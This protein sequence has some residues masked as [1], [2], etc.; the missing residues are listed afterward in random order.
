MASPGWRACQIL[1]EE[2]MRE[3]EGKVAVVTGAASGIGRALAER[4]ADAKM[5]VVLA[6][7]EEAPLREAQEALLE[8]GV[9][10]IAVQTDVRK[11]EAVEELQRRAIDAFGKVHVLCN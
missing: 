10:A 5:R 2:P 7:V 3:F 1:K 6:D 4:S 9:E 11:L 8:R